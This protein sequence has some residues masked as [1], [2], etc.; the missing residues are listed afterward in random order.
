[1]D[2]NN[3]FA[4]AHAK[5]APSAPSAPSALSAPKVPSASPTN[6]FE[7]AHA[8][9][10]A[11]APSGGA[12]M[13]ERIPDGTLKGD[14]AWMRFA[15]GLHD[16]TRAAQNAMTFGLRDKMAG[17]FH[18]S[19]GI[20][21]EES[22]S[23]LAQKRSPVLSAVGGAIGA[24]APAVGVSGVIGK[25]V[26]WLG[27]TAFLPTVA[28]QA[29][30]GAALSVGED[31]AHGELPDWKKAAVTAG[32]GGAAGGAF[33]LAGRALFPAARIGTAA[34][35]LSEPDITA[36]Q[37][38]SDKAKSLGVTLTLPEAVEAGGA[39]NSSAISGL[40]N[41]STNSPA[42]SRLRSDFVRAREAEIPSAARKVAGEIGSGQ[43]GYKTQQAATDAIDNARGLVNRASRPFYER[44]A[45][46]IVPEVPNTPSI[47]LAKK[48]VLKDPVVMGELNGAPQ[49][50]VTF[51]DAVKKAMDTMKA[52]AKDSNKPKPFNA[53]IIGRNTKALTSATDAAAPDYAAARRIQTKG[54]ERLVEPLEGGALG[55]ISRTPNA[56]SQAQA[57]FG[58]TNPIEQASALAAVKRLPQGV[59]EGLL[60]NRISSMA[61][62]N[63]LSIGTKLLPTDEARAVAA[64]VAGDKM[65]RIEDLISTMK[66]INQKA[67]EPH[68]GQ[69]SHSTF[70]HYGPVA[71]AYHFVRNLGSGGVV[72]RMHSGDA[73]NTLM[74]ILAAQR[75]AQSLGG[76][77]ADKSINQFAPSL[78]NRPKQP[79]LGGYW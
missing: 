58:V 9:L 70:G 53:S 36:A 59:P 29:A 5:F 54:R 76:V 77:T 28:N 26:P 71:E 73:A 1:M 65:P 57:L 48:S 74:K 21:R 79:V 11:S 30:T 13:G 24:V 39:K 41:T 17:L 23:A 19:E 44:S 16:M 56:A 45:G 42:G 32:V 46:V 27:K 15:S 49:N 66:A 2:D 61:S 6:P 20:K 72:S 78:R 60:G 37:A 43:P 33:N 22:E 40:Y 7:A 52:V 35:E 31:A 47:A 38:A 12:T 14:P 64:K 69:Y 25:A 51:L 62:T 67:S 8:R 4:A 34:S 68:V 3:P 10:T 18:G 50:S 63:P 55:D 75:A